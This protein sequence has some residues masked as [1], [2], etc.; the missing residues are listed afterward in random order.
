MKTVAV[1]FAILTLPAI[2]L[3]ATIYVPDDYP[4]IQN[5]IDKARHGDTVIVRPGTYVENI[6]FMGKIIVVRSEQGPD[7]TTID[8]NQEGSVVTF[9]N[10]EWADAV[11]MGFEITNGSGLWGYEGGGIYCESSSPTIKNNINTVRDYGGGIY[12]TVSSATIVNNMIINNTARDGGAIYSRYS[13]PM[14]SNNIIKGNSAV[15]SGGGIYCW[16]SSPKIS[17][18]IIMENDGMWGGGIDCNDCSGMIGNNILVRNNASS[19][20]GGGIVCI[21]SSTVI[22]RNIIVDNI[23][24]KKGG[25]IYLGRDDCTPVIS[26]NVISRNIANGSGGGI[27]CYDDS[28]PILSNNIISG[29]SA[30]HY[31][32]GI[33]CRKSSQTITNSTI[34]DNTATERGGGIFCNNDCSTTVA[35]TIFWNNG[36]PSGPEIQIQSTSHTSTFTISFSDVDG[37]QSS[38][39]VKPGCT[40]N[41]GPGMI[42][43][44][45]LFVDQAN[46]DYHLTF[47]SPCINQ[48]FDHGYLPLK[49]FE[50][51]PRVAGGISDIGADEYYHHLYHVGDIVPGGNIDI[52]VIGMPGTSPVR[53]LLAA[54]AQKNHQCTPYGKLY[55]VQPI[56][57]FVLGGIPSNGVFNLSGTVPSWWVPGKKHFLQAMIGPLGGPDTVLTNPY[58]LKVE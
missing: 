20:D 1:L 41:W 54:N 51:D 30:K 16:L 34:T 37:G 14:I 22:T 46:E 56:Y 10:G 35:N 58:V 9:Q 13:S 55:L 29:N 23:S 49:D 36:S 6:D 18:N 15:Y 28:S 11:L 45:P 40:L 5:A 2:A 57:E 52:R 19:Y 44:D 39:L 26:N 8:G 53:L 17:D 32:G 27:C 3:S 48:G 38:V 43:A 42:D 50:R 25:G 7:V 24:H 33:Y 4:T 31:G 12:C 21:Y 47:N